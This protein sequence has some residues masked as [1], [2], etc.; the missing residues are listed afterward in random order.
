MSSSLSTAR[1]CEAQASHGAILLFLPLALM[2][3]LLNSSVPTPLY[4]HY[5]QAL[6]LSDVSL[7][8]IYGGYAAGVL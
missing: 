1:P 8:L 7:T 5:Q 3:A 4:P 2:S 6:A